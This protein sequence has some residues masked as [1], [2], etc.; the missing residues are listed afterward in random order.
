MPHLKAGRV[1][2][3]VPR[4]AG[5]VA[6][7]EQLPGPAAGEEY[8]LVIP[9]ANARE[10]IGFGPQHAGP[11]LGEDILT[12]MRR[13]AFEHDMILD[14]TSYAGTSNED[15]NVLTNAA[16]STSPSGNALTHNAELLFSNAA[17]D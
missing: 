2:P 3:T 4:F 11:F 6:E 9:A 10:P 5:I 17:G 13:A 16:N 14:A 1:G 15:D 7:I 12:R 8:E